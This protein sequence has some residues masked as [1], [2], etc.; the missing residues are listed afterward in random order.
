MGKFNLF[1]LSHSTYIIFYSKPK[2][3]KTGESKFELQ[4]IWALQKC[5]KKYKRLNTV[6]K[7]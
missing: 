7:L 2:N 6:N 1:S 4:L 3:M 5:L